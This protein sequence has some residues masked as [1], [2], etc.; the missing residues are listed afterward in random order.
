MNGNPVREMEDWLAFA[1]ELI[2]LLRRSALNEVWICP[3]IG[4]VRGGYG[5]SSFPPSW[6]QAIALHSLLRQRWQAP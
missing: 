1:E 4:P 3:E 6:E 5:L 2:R